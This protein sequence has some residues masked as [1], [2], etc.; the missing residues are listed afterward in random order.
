MFNRAETIPALEYEQK[1]MAVFDGDTVATDS[2]ELLE[3]FRAGRTLKGKYADAIKAYEAGKQEHIISK[4]ESN[5]QVSALELK[6]VGSIK[7]QLLRAGLENYFAELV[8]LIN[9]YAQH[10]TTYY[11]PLLDN[12]LI[13]LG[14]VGDFNDYDA[15]NT[16]CDDNKEDR[17][18]CREFNAVRA[19]ADKLKFHQKNEHITRLEDTKKSIDLGTALVTLAL[20]REVT[21]DELDTMLDNDDYSALDLIELKHHRGWSFSCGV[22][23]NDGASSI[24]K[25]MLDGLARLNPGLLD[26]SFAIESAITYAVDNKIDFDRMLVPKD[27]FIQL[28]GVLLSTQMIT[29]AQ[30]NQCAEKIHE[31]QKV[32]KNCPYNKFF[33]QEGKA[34]QELL[35]A[36][37]KTEEVDRILLGFYTEVLLVVKNELL[38]IEKERTEFNQYMSDLKLLFATD[39]TNDN[40][41]DIADKVLAASIIVLA[42]TTVFDIAK[43]P[44]AA[45]IKKIYDNQDNLKTLAVHPSGSKYFAA[46]NR[47]AQTVLCGA[48][49][50]DCRLKADLKNDLKASYR[51][52][53]DQLAYLMPENYMCGAGI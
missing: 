44:L 31:V 11:R 36:N 16:F 27:L 50:H 40:R 46:G 35:K 5:A 48:P 52:S 9:Q 39:I 37:D 6:K 15:I 19:M 13:A 24:K 21:P 14:Y 33:F 41:K 18:R 51:A 20:N 22:R 25:N 7:N 34:L 4:L 42:Y 1:V 29:Q 45:A 23:I 2:A 47:S 53:Y 28:P 26:P 3:T 17:E 8:V 30:I 38:S 10:S 43:L 49:P 12:K 32:L